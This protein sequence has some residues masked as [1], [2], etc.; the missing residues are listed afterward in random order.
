[1]IKTATVLLFISI[2]IK[3]TLALSLMTSASSSESL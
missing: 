3:T 1:M 2:G